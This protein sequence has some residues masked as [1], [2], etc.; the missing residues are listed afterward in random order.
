MFHTNNSNSPFRDPLSMTLAQEDDWKED[1]HKS[2]ETS[3]IIPWAMN[4]MISD[5]KGQ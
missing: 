5:F 4:S 1:D 2:G 3:S